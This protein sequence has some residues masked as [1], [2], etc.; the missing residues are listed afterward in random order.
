MNDLFSV[1]PTVIVLYVNMS[2]LLDF[3][4]IVLYCSVVLCNIMNG[5]IETSV[6]FGEMYLKSVI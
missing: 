2:Y 3:D 1:C 4:V 6:E 5:R